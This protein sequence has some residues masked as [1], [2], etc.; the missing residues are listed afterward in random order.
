MTSLTRQTAAR[1]WRCFCCVDCHVLTEIGNFSKRL[2]LLFL[3]LRLLEGGPRMGT[4][5]L[6]HRR[7]LVR[8]SVGGRLN[9][10]FLIWINLAN[11]K[12]QWRWIENGISSRQGIVFI[13]A[14]RD[15]SCWRDA[16]VRLQSE[17]IHVWKWSKQMR[18]QIFFLL[19]WF[20]IGPV[21]HVVNA[22]AWGTAEAAFMR[23][24]WHHGCCWAVCLA[25]CVKVMCQGD[26]AGPAK[27]PMILQRIFLNIRAKSLASKRPRAFN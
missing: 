4:N 8:L 17:A 7:I 24:D 3:L 14:E 22:N 23:R 20:F 19:H 10:S 11:W 2:L 12:D 15:T 16:N 13:T 25:L 5:T 21:N 6:W 9:R 27:I 1:Q 18:H 26:S